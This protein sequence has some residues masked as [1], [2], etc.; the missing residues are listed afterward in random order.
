M[1]RYRQRERNLMADGLEADRADEAR[2]VVCALTNA[3]VDTSTSAT[4]PLRCDPDR[5]TRV[6]NHRRA[7]GRGGHLLERLG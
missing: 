5:E 6:D 7:L 2:T 3:W 1:I 4:E